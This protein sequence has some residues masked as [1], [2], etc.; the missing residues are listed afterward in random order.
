MI[1]VYPDRDVSSR[2]NSSKFWIIIII[3]VQAVWDK[4]N[5][6]TVKLKTFSLSLADQH[7][8]SLLLLRTE[9][10]FNHLAENSAFGILPQSKVITPKL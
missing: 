8:S 7:L 10:H 3:I 9:L 5:Q 1:H 6:K 4:L 2:L